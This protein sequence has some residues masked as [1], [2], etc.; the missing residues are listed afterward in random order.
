MTTK[1]FY[2]DGSKVGICADTITVSILNKSET[3]NIFNSVIGYSTPVYC[4]FVF[5]LILRFD[6][7]TFGC[8]SFTLLLLMRINDNISWFF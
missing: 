5:I 3:K 1:C 7:S 8:S 2:P 6:L 4:V